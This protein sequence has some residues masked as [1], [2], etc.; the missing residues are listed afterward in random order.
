MTATL[1]PR[2]VNE[3]ATCPVPARVGLARVGGVWRVLVGRLSTVIVS[4]A[5]NGGP[6]VHQGGGRS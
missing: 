2:Q 3:T 5:I 4:W 6:V 1:G